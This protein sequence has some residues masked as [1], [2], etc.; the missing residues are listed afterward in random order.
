MCFSLTWASLRLSAVPGNLLALW[1][2]ERSSSTAPAHAGGASGAAAAHN[3]TAID[4]TKHGWTDS[5]VQH[6]QIRR[7]AHESLNVH[8]RLPISADSWHVLRVFAARLRGTR[9]AL[10]ARRL[11]PAAGAHRDRAAAARR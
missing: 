3:G 10:P 9:R 7:S 6:P 11:R 2:L 8:A 4:V 5:S 1:L